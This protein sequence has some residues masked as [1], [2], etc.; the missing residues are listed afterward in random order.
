MS[1]LEP[2]T[3][4]PPASTVSLQ[5]TKSSSQLSQNQITQYGSPTSQQK[6]QWPK[7][8]KVVQKTILETNKEPLPWM[9]KQLRR[10]QKEENMSLQVREQKSSDVESWRSQL[11]KTQ[12][13]DDDSPGE[14][15]GGGENYGDH[16]KRADTCL[17]CR[18]E[19]PSPSPFLANAVE[20]TPDVTTEASEAAGDTRQ[21][22]RNEQSY[23]VNQKRL[24][25]IRISNSTQSTSQTLQMTK[26]ES[27]T[28]THVSQT[29]EAVPSDLDSAPVEEARV[30]SAE[31]SSVEPPRSCTGDV[32]VFSPMPIMPPNHT[33]SWKERYLNLTAE[34][35]QL[36]AEIVSQEQHNSPG[37]VDIETNASQSD[38]DL[39]V[40]GLTI[41][42]HLKGKDDLIINTDLTQVSSNV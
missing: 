42:M 30:D 37:R 27:D 25:E 32:E 19:T 13:L 20:L 14:Q 39:G 40:E 4:S 23:R 17:T 18:H 12:A 41:V 31:Q 34:V 22:G 11:R 21:Q 7:L 36:K 35:R 2:E 28:V 16:N 26:A 9:R 15:Y 38:N 1:S 6:I 8:K 5:S 3:R 24:E 29:S 33:C 10:V